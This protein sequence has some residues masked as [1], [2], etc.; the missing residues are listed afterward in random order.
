LF[1]NATQ[2]AITVSNSTL[3]WSV[4][5][6]SSG[7]KATLTFVAG[8]TTNGTFSTTATVIA[9]QADP[10]PANNSATVV[11]VVTAP[12]IAIG[13][14][15]AT[16]TYE[17][18][19]VNGA[20][21]PGET[22][23]LIL[24]LRDI[25]NVSTRNLVGT[26]VTNSGVTPL[27][28]NNPQTFGV[29]APSGFP[30]GRSFSF[31]A[32][33]TN[34]QTIYPTLQLRDGTTNYPP[35]VF[36]FILPR[37]SG[38]ANTDAITIPDPAAP[39]PRYQPQSGPA[40][41]YPSTINVSNL[42][43]VLGKVTVTFSNLTH[44]FP[45]DIN[46][47]L[48]A[49]NGVKTLLMS[50]AGDQPAAGLMLTFDDGAPYPLPALGGLTPGTWRPAA[51]SPAP[52]FPTNAPVGPYNAAL[53][54]FNSIN[55]NGTW[56][57]YVFDDTGGDAGGIVGGWSLALS[58]LTPVNQLA[59]LGISGVVVPATCL[60]G[61]M[62]TYTFAI[63]NAG[64]NT[65]TSVAFTNLLPAGITLISA[66][67]SQG[68]VLTNATSVIG[69]LGA[70]NA[71]TNAFMTVVVTPTAAVFSVGATNAVFTNTANV[72]ADETDLNPG[73]NTVSISTAIRRPVVNLGLGQTVVPNPLVVGYNLTNTI[74]ITNSG[75]DMALNAVLTQ[76][77]P[78]GAGFVLASSS[79]G[80]CTN[81]AGAVI[82]TLG[83]LASNTTA[84]V[85][86]ILTNSVAGLMTNRVFLAT[87]SYDP[88]PANHSATYVTTVEDPAPRIINVG[89]VLT[90]E[91]GP[92]NGAVDPGETVTLLLGL[93]NLG[94]LDTFNLKATL[95]ASGGVT[96]PTAPQYYGSLIQG[97]PS[98][99]RSFGFKAA[100]V[101]GSTVVATLQL[102][103]ER[104]GVTNNLGTVTFTFSPPATSQWSSSA[105]L[106]IPD[107]GV[108]VPYPSMIAVTGLVGRVS[109]AT[110]TLKGLTHTFP[111]D[112]SALLVSPSGKS[113]LV[114]SHTGGGNAVTN[115]TLTFDD[116]AGGSLANY[117]TLSSGSS[118]P[119]SYQ[120]PVIL[121]SPAP[122]KS[123]SLALSDLNWSDP[124]GAWLLYVYDDAVGDGGR[125]VG[126]WSLSLTTLVTVGPV[127]DL[128]VGMSRAPAMLFVGDHLTNTITVTNLGPDWAT[129]VI[130]TNTLPAGVSFV[131]AWLSQG[132]VSSTGGGA[133]V[134]SLGGLPAGQGAQAIIV[135]VPSVAGTLVATA[136][137][138]ANEE[139]L[140]PTNSFA[141]TSTTVLGFTPATLG[142]FMSNGQFH[143][144]VSGQA[145]VEYVILGSTNLTSWISLSTNIASPTGTI[146]YIDT[147]STTLGQRYY[148]TL[149]LTP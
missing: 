113:V 21:D 32:S 142:G 30:V 1:T 69:S 132:T 107:H 74:L 42:T 95:Q 59:D 123:Y 79:V 64:P 56:S 92:A 62:L 48:V 135:T 86:I 148:R 80:T 33:G 34:G 52:V 77:L 143:L 70:L 127:V 17:S 110:V 99:S 111:H 120:G 129:D 66:H 133:V 93:A 82:C 138:V 2:G 22:V 14:A 83:N 137:A 28:P 145:N 146:T 104:P 101:L 38:F 97:G 29:L 26:L 76:V 128:A 98:A 40:N 31:T 7:A 50:H 126:G 16:L 84:T 45:G 60:A 13:A 75:P 78:P 96:L 3:F 117:G 25:G 124:N 53:S 65:A 71:G 57:L 23:T 130:L 114:M 106:T 19:P 37:V 6:L 41:P 140:Y 81:T 134:C 121:P 18:G 44:T 147:N 118:K 46:A 9:A 149:R 103:D 20:I 55:P 105:A 144:T 102:L 68:K 43:G 4:G 91:S 88:N 11:T 36:S 5:T 108:A 100:A 49:P 141:L 90:Y 119:T 131:S 125:I 35:V 122:A 12:F 136:F 8:T 58:M 39:Y 115:I 15:T 72:A 10:N 67:P 116:A 27:P 63:T 87:D 112:V 139:D 51:Y 109:K 61:E 89:A 94:T 24:R 85:T 54:S 73:N 47:L